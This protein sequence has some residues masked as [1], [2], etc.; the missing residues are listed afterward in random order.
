MKDLYVNAIM[1]SFYIEIMITSLILSV[2]RGT[3]LIR[4]IFIFARAA[5]T[6]MQ[7]FVWNILEL[8]L[9]FTLRTPYTLYNLLNTFLIL[10]ANVRT[11]IAARVFS[12][13][14]RSFLKLRILLHY[15]ELSIRRN[16]RIKKIDSLEVENF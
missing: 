3:C 14:V 15:A 13:I 6:R 5:W 1:R 16:N 11:Y 4:S 10:F 8:R 7:I 2:F 12:E 9:Q